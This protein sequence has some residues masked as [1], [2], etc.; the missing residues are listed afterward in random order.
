M[1]GRIMAHMTMALPLRWAG[2][3]HVKYAD[4]SFLVRCCPLVLILIAAAQRQ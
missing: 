4:T 3:N 2:R 1:D